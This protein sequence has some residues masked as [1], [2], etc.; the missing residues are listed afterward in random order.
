MSN[1]FCDW[2]ETQ[3]SYSMLRES[4]RRRHQK[5]GNKQR[6]TGS[7]S[8]NIIAGQHRH[9]GQQRGQRNMAGKKAKAFALRSFVAPI[10]SLQ[11]NAEVSVSQ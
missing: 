3:T 6:P 1:G 4:I 11:S 2:V 5:Q 7:R 8:E 10:V 9:V